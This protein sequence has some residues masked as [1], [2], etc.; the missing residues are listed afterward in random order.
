MWHTCRGQPSRL[1]HRCLAPASTVHALVVCEVRCQPQGVIEVCQ[2]RSGAL[3][4]PRL[5]SV[6]GDND[7]L[8]IEEGLEHPV[9]CNRH[10]GS[11]VDFSQA[12]EPVAL[13]SLPLHL[14]K[15]QSHPRRSVGRCWPNTALVRL[16]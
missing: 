9:P 16:V 10:D 15:R 5:M 7:Y 13:L 12:G 4:M 11:T 2:A 8:A 3:L 6:C 1:Q 14:Q